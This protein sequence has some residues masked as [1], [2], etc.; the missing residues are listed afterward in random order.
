MLIEAEMMV[1]W[2]REAI[3]HGDST[4]GKVQYQRSVFGSQLRQFRMMMQLATLNTK[5]E[6]AVLQKKTVSFIL[7]SSGM[8]SL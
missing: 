6:M 1:A 4:R 2:V 8:K 7:F 5:E 3:L